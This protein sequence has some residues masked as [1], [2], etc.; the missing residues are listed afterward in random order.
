MDTTFGTQHPL[1]QVSPLEETS[2]ARR[3]EKGEQKSFR[4]QAATSCLGPVQPLPATGALAS[5]R[6]C[7]GG[8]L[9]EL[10]SGRKGW[11]VSVPDGRCG[12]RNLL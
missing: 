2:H 7:T 5:S 10:C 4:E 3:Q 11:D 6:Q 9:W 1:C 8:S 12:F